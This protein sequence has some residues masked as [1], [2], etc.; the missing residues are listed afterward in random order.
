MTEVEANNLPAKKT[1]F[2]DGENLETSFEAS[3]EAKWD[4]PVLPADEFG[5]TEDIEDGEEDGRPKEKSKKG[6][7]FFGFLGALILAGAGYGYL[8]FAEKPIDVAAVSPPEATSAE[9][10]LAE[11]LTSPSA[12]PVEEMKVEDGGAVVSA[13]Q[14]AEAVSAP[15]A[16]KP[17]N[18]PAPEAQELPKFSGAQTVPD[19]KIPESL[20]SPAPALPAVTPTTS[21]VPDIAA[22]STVAPVELA[23]AAPV[24]APKEQISSQ[25]ADNAGQIQP[26]AAASETNPDPTVSG[27]PAPKVALPTEMPPTTEPPSV[28]TLPATAPVAAVAVPTESVVTPPVEAQKPGNS[29]ADATAAVK[30]KPAPSVVKPR[31]TKAPVSQAQGVKQKKT[32]APSVQY[33]LKSAMT[34]EAW[35]SSKEKPDELRSLR[36]GDVVP[37]LG[38]IKSIERENGT[39]VVVGTAGMLK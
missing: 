34:G 1:E 16:V 23:A 14:P 5:D 30:A 12:Q 8:H 25:Q 15:E 37:G 24:L 35:V 7:L 9:P 33:I 26:P 31:T 4:E 21:A 13:A 2:D 17:A 38:K 22:V 3:A 39:W 29:A 10:K 28:K 27:S 19:S 18:A 36:V 32:P 11:M 6:L 20:A